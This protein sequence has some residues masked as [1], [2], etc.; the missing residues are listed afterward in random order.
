M[1]RWRRQCQEGYEIVCI[2]SDD[3]VIAAAGFRELS[4][5]AWGRILYL[6]DLVAVPDHRGMGL[7]SA[8]LRFLQAET[9]RRGCEELHLDTG[10]ARHAAH[11]SYLRNGFDIVCHHMSWDAQTKRAA[12]A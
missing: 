6:D 1:E 9:I 2:R 12:D 7:G 10:Y 5:M 3:L 4:T 8:L 11:K